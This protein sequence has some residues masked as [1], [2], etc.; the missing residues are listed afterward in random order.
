MIVTKEI[1]DPQIDRCPAKHAA[2]PMCFF[3]VLWVPGFL[4][5]GMIR[6][7]DMVIGLSKILY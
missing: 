1:R 3:G 4:N 5:R 7:P 6:F 2:F